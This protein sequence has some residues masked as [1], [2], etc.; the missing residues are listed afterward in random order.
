MNIVQ[1][2]SNIGNDDLTTIIVAN[3]I[4][5]GIVPEILILVEPMSLHNDTLLKNYSWI[6]NLI[7]ENLVVDVVSNVEKDFFYHLDNIPKYEVAS[8]SKD[9]IMRYDGDL[10]RIVSLKIKTININDLFRKYNLKDIDILFIDAEGHDDTIIYSIDFD[11]FNIKKI[12]FENACLKNK[13]IYDFLKSKNYS[14]IK[15]VSSSTTL[16]E[17][18]K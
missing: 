8:L 10:D 17:K 1:I 3:Y 16:A 18:N 4:F 5:K 2:G 6:K 7:I 11:N 12:Y 9:H 13:M 15:E 14:I